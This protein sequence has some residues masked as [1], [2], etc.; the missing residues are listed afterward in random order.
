MK[1]LVIEDSER[2]RRSL[3]L[4]L[5]RSGFAVDLAADGSEGLEF[6]QA[7]EYD[8]IVLDLMLPGLPGL[9]VLERI[10]ADEK[11]VF[12]LI[13]SARDQVDDRVRGLAAGADDYL[14][15]PFAF[16]E[17]VA[18]LQALT[19]RRHN[20]SRSSLE[21][22][23]LEVDLARREARRAGR[24]VPL[25]RG[26]YAILETLALRRGRVV[27]KRELLEL[28]NDGQAEVT[29]NAVEVLVSGL[30]R[31]VAAAGADSPVRTR[32]GYGYYVD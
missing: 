30:R 10:R 9:Q 1:L 22:G 14:I 8:A 16:D 31:K 29:E 3:G 12:V 21:V 15:K 18:R 19:R 5:R 20:L 2:L 23:E 32:R 17:L 7:Y 27:S 6:A 28:L 13:L 25:T 11:D 4:G 26:E 24:A